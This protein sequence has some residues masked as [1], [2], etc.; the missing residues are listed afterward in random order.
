LLRELIDARGGHWPSA[1]EC[2]AEQL[3][4]AAIGQLWPDLEQ[5]AGAWGGFEKACQQAWRL[6][7]QGTAARV[8]H[9]REHARFDQSRYQREHVIEAMHDLR[10]TRRFWPTQWEYDDWAR[11]ERRTMRLT[12]E[13]APRPSLTRIRELFTCWD[14]ALEIAIRAWELCSMSR[15]KFQDKPFRRGQRHNGVVELRVTPSIQATRLADEFFARRYET[16][17]DAGDVVFIGRP[18]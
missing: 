17:A 5:L 11:C 13:N 16:A 2:V 4:R 6:W 12:G 1:D 14:R 18:V 9:T 10:S 15:P 8:A 7:E 3:A